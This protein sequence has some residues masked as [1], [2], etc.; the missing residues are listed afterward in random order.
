MLNRVQIRHNGHNWN[1]ADMSIPIYP[2]ALCSYFLTDRT[3]GLLGGE[4]FWKSI[5]FGDYAS[6]ER[7]QLFSQ[8]QPFLNTPR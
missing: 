7:E 2:I 8:N 1:S 6:V 4:M 5:D 3:S